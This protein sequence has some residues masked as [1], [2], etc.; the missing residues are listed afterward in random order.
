MTWIDE[1][2]E[3]R[4]ARDRAIWSRWGIASL[5]H[6]HWLGAAPMNFPGLP[7]T[8]RVESRAVIG[9]DGPDRPFVTLAVGEEM[10]FGTLRLRVIERDGAFALRVLDPAA[11]TRRGISAIESFPLSDA[12]IREGRFVAEVDV[13]SDEVTSVDGNVAA[14]DFAG[15][16]YFEVGGVGLGLRV[17]RS[18][19]ALTAVFS[20]GTSGDESYRFRFLRLP[21]PDPDGRVE[22]DLNRAYLPPCA[23]SDEY[24]C[25]MP[26]VGNRWAVP[27]RAGERTVR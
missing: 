2:R 6:T 10:E 21:M 22:V 27:I 3:W 4:T 19:D 1:H 26:S 17:S 20:D 7:G 9:E 25:V 12:W 8:W 15:S 18:A 24:L 23:F 16:V 14:H 11:A 5:A 13:R